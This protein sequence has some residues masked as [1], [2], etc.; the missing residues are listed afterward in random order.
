MALPTC[1]PWTNNTIR[2]SDQVAA[3]K[4]RSA[5]AGS[6]ELQDVT[7]LLTVLDSL[8][9][10]AVVSAEGFE[11]LS[12]Y[13][14][15][16]AEV[17]AHEAYVKINTLSPPIQANSAELKQMILWQLANPLCLLNA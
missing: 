16:D 9:R 17:N 7:F 2:D 8:Q 13:E 1:N 5:L 3:C 15:C 14:M 10:L 12:A 11:N 4:E 6:Q